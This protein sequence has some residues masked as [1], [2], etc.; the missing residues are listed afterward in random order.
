MTT[1]V[2]CDHAESVLGQK[3]HLSI[4]RV[5]IQWPSMRKR[6]YRAFAPVF[7][8]DRRAI[9][10]CNCAH[11][12]VLLGIVCET[13]ILVVCLISSVL[14]RELLCLSRGTPRIWRV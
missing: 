7:V 11:T 2:V 8:V 4:P 1:S 5:R 9:F 12:K 3:K 13:E 10:D 14:V 6:D